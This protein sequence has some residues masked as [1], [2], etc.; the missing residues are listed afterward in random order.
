MDIDLEAERV[1]IDGAWLTRDEISGRIQQMLAA[2]DFRI[3]RLSEALEQLAQALSGSRTL[4][5]KL[6]AEQYAKLESAGGRLGKTGP[7]Y[8]RELLMQVLSSAVASGPSSHPPA[9]SATPAHG[10]PVI[11]AAPPPPLSIPPAVTSVPPAVSGLA[12]ATTS[13]VTPEE[14]AAALSIPPKRRGDTLP[15]VPPVMTPIANVPVSVHPGGDDDSRRPAG[16][17]GDGRRWFNRS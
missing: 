1:N 2:G 12:A 7:G 11:I 15:G 8:A 3:V 6:T 9:V 5:M 17:P 14:A 16:G 13:D 10:V 4:T